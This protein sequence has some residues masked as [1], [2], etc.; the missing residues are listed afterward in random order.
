[1]SGMHRHRVKRR[2]P[3]GAIQLAAAAL[4]NGYAAGFVRGGLYQGPLKRACVPVLNCWS[5]PGALG[6]CPIG[7][8]QA[9]LGAPGRR[10]FPFYVLGTLMLFGVALG[11]LACGLLCPFGFVQDLLYKIPV[12]K[13]RPPRR[14]DRPLRYVKY[15]VLA[16]L[17]ALPL[18][19]RPAFG[20]APPY[21]CKYLCPAGTLE[22]GIPQ[23]LL[24][25]SLRGLAGALFDW[26]VIVLVALVALATKVGRPFCRY[27][28]PLGALYG[29]FNRFSLSRMALDQHKC[30]HCGACERA[31]PMQVDVTKA[32]NSAECIRCG[33]CAGVCPVDA[34]RTPIFE[35]KEKEDDKPIPENAG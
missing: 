4:F 2:V 26:K 12:K 28:C 8:L 5:C 33:R 19:L 27:L 24:N 17:V 23:V 15:A 29:L 35:R 30:V 22:A 34:I 14:L 9:A 31:C 10:R 25:P 3:R 16:A 21:F 20:G 13:W 6:A 7:A 1:M 32:I 11:R 18:V